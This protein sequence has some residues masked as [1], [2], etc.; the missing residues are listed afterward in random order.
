MSFRAPP[1]ADDR[2]LEAKNPLSNDDTYYI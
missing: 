2:R 1:T